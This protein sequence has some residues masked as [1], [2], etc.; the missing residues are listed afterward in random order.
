MAKLV[1][2]IKCYRICPTKAMLRF[3]GGIAILQK[4]RL[5]KM[6]INF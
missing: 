1:F 4:A 2:A 5:N 6:N 3:F